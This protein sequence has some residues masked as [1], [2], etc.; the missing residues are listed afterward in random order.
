MRRCCGGLFSLVLRLLVV[1]AAIGGLVAP[2]AVAKSFPPRWPQSPGTHA[3]GA[4]LAPRGI[5]SPAYAANLRGGFAIVGNTLLT[6]PENL[7]PPPWRPTDAITCSV[8][9]NNDKSM[10]YVNVDPG[11]NPARFNSSTAT[12]SFRRGPASRRRTCTGGPISRV[13]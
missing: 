8:A 2:D 4:H 3:A 9:N 13:A 6:C 5:A 11:G 12:L 7:L 10:R 1:A